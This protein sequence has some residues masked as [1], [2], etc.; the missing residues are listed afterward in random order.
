MSQRL[1]DK[2]VA[3]LPAPA[4]GIPIVVIVIPGVCLLW[5]QSGHGPFN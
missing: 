5:T 3:K 1:T 4:T 2:I